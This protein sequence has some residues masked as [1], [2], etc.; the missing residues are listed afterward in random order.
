MSTPERPVVRVGSPAGV[1]AVIPYLLGFVPEAS[2]VVAGT[3][4]RGGRIH[5]LMRYDLPDP[6]DAEL[7]AGIG[8]HA[9]AGL[10]FNQLRVVLVAGY[11]PGHLVTP[12][13]DALRQAAGAAGVRL[14]DVLRVEGGRYWSYLCTDPACCPVHRESLRQWCVFGV[15]ATETPG[16]AHQL[17]SPSALS[18]ALQVLGRHREPPQ[19]K[20]AACRA[21]LERTLDAQLKEVGSL[22]DGG[23][24]DAAQK[25]L[26]EIDRRFA[27]L[28]APR[29]LAL[30]SAL[31]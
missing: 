13:A 15:E 20:L 31:H 7:A 1:L 5:F 6:P 28:A 12:V 16:A 29:S 25:L 11:G 23:Q 4:R 8:V 22:L 24:R 14:V 21:D 17:A 10:E 18:G 19:A 30:W 2:L 3:G 26:L 9:M 27:G